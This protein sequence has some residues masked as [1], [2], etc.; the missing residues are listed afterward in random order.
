MIVMSMR[1]YDTEFLHL[2]SRLGLRGGGRVEPNPMVGCVLVC[3]DVPG[4]PIVQ[5]MGHHR[6]FGGLHAEAEALADALHK[7]HDVRG[8]TAYVTLE[9]CHAYGRQPPCS[10]ALVQAGIARVV[11]AR[12]D[13][14]PSKAGGAAWLRSQGV[15][16]EQVFV[17]SLG[18]RSERRLAEFVGSPFIKRLTTDQPWVIA[19]WAQRQDGEMRFAADGTKWISCEA[20]RR[21]VHRWR[22]RVDAIITG[23]GTVLADDPLLTVRGI[24]R[25]R[26]TPMRVVLDG[27]LRTPMN[28][29]LVHTLGQ[30]P[31][32]VLHGPEETLT[33][34]A[35]V[36]RDRL[37]ALGVLVQGIDVRGDSHQHAS[38]TSPR[39]SLDLRA[40][41]AILRAHFG[42]HTAMLETGPMLLAEAF[43]RGV[44][45]QAIVYVADGN[46][47]EPLR[48]AIAEAM[49]ANGPWDLV[50][51]RCV[52]SDQE[53]HLV[54]R[55]WIEAR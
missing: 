47:E 31:V 10:R 4:G 15:A 26:R 46:P 43:T 37:L 9:P 29:A 17:Q 40:A 48:G 49:R 27:A 1:L 12:R 8:S 19:K 3:E 38:E 50:R 51:R 34:E 16:C 23:I 13:P 20:S 41:L 42:V 22:A 25:P 6:V 24:T 54:K 44:V 2:A 52:Q 33:A 32:L 53:L 21:R 55:Q 39:R 11:F 18:E 14:N 45:D 5:G 7:G 28:S 35:R 36:R 30:G